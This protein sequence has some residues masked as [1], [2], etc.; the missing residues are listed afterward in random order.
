LGPDLHRAVVVV[1]ATALLEALREKI[2]Q[3]GKGELLMN[4]ALADSVVGKVDRPTN[5]PPIRSVIPAKPLNPE[6]QEALR[7]A[8]SD[9]VTYLWGPPGTGKT[10]VLSDV[11]RAAFEN[12]KRVLIC[13]NTNKAVDQV[14]FKICESLGR[15]HPAMENGHIVRM[16]RIA[17]D[18]LSAQYEQY[19]TVDGIVERKSVELKAR[20][21]RAHEA[22]ARIDAKTAKA[23]N[24]VTQFLELE[25]V[26]KRVEH[27]KEATNNAARAGKE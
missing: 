27:Q 4:R 25:A 16:G 7:R 6:Q 22:L 10:H 23:R 18:K 17:L 13:S 11:V 20:Q 8:L 19:V 3:I 2:E 14:L 5:P 21:L 12:D 1:D 24:V 15:A 26:K 9:S